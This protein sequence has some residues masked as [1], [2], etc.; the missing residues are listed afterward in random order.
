M[1]TKPPEPD[2]TTQGPGEENGTDGHQLLLIIIRILQK[3][4][5][6]KCDPQLP[7]KIDASK[8]LIYRSHF[9]LDFARL[10]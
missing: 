7:V 9:S 6:R 10:Q 3:Q 2:Q 5:G 8:G 4:V 1:I